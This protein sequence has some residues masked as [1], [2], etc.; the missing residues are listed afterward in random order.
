MFPQV[1]VQYALFLCHS[2]TEG[3]P[4]NARNCAFVHLCI[5]RCTNEHVHDRFSPIEKKC[6]FVHLCMFDTSQ[7]S[8]HQKADFYNFDL[9]PITKHLPFVSPTDKQKK[10]NT[11]SMLSDASISSESLMSSDASLFSSDESRSHR[12]SLSDDTINI[13]L[14][15]RQQTKKKIKAAT[16]QCL[17]GQ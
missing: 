2:S 11:T 15:S 1:H 4:S 6:A 8:R 14:F 16:I 12:S 9:V 13:F 3:V 5:F 7:W 10:F 17:I